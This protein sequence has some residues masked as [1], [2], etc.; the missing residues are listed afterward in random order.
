M[1]DLL[2]VRWLQ[3]I[4]TTELFL[5]VGAKARHVPKASQDRGEIVDVP[6]DGS[7]KDRRIVRIE[8]GTHHG[9]TTT[10]LVEEH[11][12]R[13]QVKDLMQGVNRKDEEEGGNGVSLT[14]SATML[15]RWTRQPI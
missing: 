13:R 12:P 11:F 5:E 6:F 15:D 3:R 4:G 8:G 9:P 2:K 7:H 1:K 10:D 14:E